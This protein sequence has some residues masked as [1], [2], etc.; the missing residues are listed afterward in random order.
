MVPNKCVWVRGTKRKEPGA[1][2]PTG[3]AGGKGKGGGKNGRP[4]TLAEMQNGAKICDAWNK[5]RCKGTCPNGQL[6]VCNGKMKRSDDRKIACGSK[7]HTSA[8]CTRCLRL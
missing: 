8:E 7:E 3:K 1:D 5:G 6:H 2:N 4:V